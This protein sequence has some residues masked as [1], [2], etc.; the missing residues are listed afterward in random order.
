MSTPLRVCLVYDRLFPLSLGGAERWYRNL[1]EKLIDR[2]LRVNYLTLRHRPS[3]RQGGISGASVTMVGPAMDVYSKGRRRVLPPMLFG[4]GVLFHLLRHGRDYDV[5]HTAS[6][7]YFSVLAAAL[8]RPWGRYRLVVDWHEIWTRRAWHGYA[9][10]VAGTVGWLVQRLCLA[11]PHKAFTFSRMHADRLR[12]EG[13][14]GEPIILTGEYAGPSGGADAIT[15]APHVI[16]AGRHIPEKRVPALVEAVAH[17]R[18]RVPGLSCTIF[19]DGPQRGEVLGMVRDRRLEEV[20]QVPGFVAEE[21]LDASLREAMCLVL[22]SS[23]EGYGAVVVEALARGTPAVVVAGEENAAVELVED[24]VNGYVAATA[25]A[26]DLAGAIS[27]IYEGGV[28][29]RRSTAD[30]YERNERRLSLDGS[31]DIIVA[32][33][34]R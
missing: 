21:R 25:S 19:G 7:P 14:R 16:Y 30:W 13:L 32:G 8:V 26:E 33:Y 4:L 28:D 24:G 3:G 20:I 31:V 9:G 10:R 12:D 17:A 29:I 1:A 2:G 5:V 23:R 6:F 27:A 34:T 11:V 22:P 18:D 15:V